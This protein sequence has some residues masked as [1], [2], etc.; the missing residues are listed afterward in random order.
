MAFLEHFAH[1]IHFSFN[2]LTKAV[3]AYLWVTS[4]TL[5]QTFLNPSIL[6]I[7]KYLLSFQNSDSKSGKG[8]EIFVLGLSPILNNM[9]WYGSLENEFGLCID[10]ILKL[11]T[12]LLSWT[13]KWWFCNHLPQ[14]RTHLFWKE[15]SLSSCWAFFKN[16]NET[17]SYLFMGRLRFFT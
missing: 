1:F 9:S 2:T 10:F 14:L 11:L 15:F 5:A 3:L 16:K 4:T 17:V 8:R 7:L 6:R 12:F 13:S